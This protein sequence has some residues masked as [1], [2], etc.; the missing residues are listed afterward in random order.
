V[1]KS[2][3]CVIA[4]YRADSR[5]QPVSQRSESH[6]L[7]V[8]M[9]RLRIPA[10]AFSFPSAHQVGI[11]QVRIQFQGLRKRG[12]LHRH[13]VLWSPGILCIVGFRQ[14]LVPRA[15]S[16]SSEIARLK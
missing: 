12:L 3:F 10:S 8:G 15:K 7:E 6:L 11:R 1:H 4:R 5:F 13:D 2:E 14:L 16:G 9:L